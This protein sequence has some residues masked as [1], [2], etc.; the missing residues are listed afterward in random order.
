MLS[1]I[2]CFLLDMDG[3]IHLSG[4]ALPG[5]PEAVARMRRQAKVIFVTNNPTLSRSGYAEKLCAMGIESADEDIYTAGNATIDYLRGYH[6]GKSVCLFGTEALKREF[7]QGGIRLTDT[8]PDIVVFTF[9]TEL[10]YKEIAKVCDFVR[11]GVPLIATH[12][13]DNCPTS[14]GC[15]PDVGS[16]LALI[17]KSTGKTPFIICGKPFWPMGDGIKKLTGC[18]SCEVA[19]IG[20]RMSTDMAFAER[21][22]FVSVL[23]L[24]G[25]TKAVP[26]DCSARLNVIL[27]SVALWDL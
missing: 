9:N 11:E 5:A 4:T 20:D 3:T 21:N 17:E 25:A 19:M 12:P 15:I 14:T 16:F 23:V 10:T 2:K 13:D 24:T 8:A 1:N 18:R 26:P 6:S 7:I 22:G 27:K